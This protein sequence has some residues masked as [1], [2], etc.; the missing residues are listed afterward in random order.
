[1]AGST[2]TQY[3][4]VIVGSGFAGSWAAKEL[5]EAGFHTLILEAGPAL[6]PDEI[7]ARA[8][9][10]G[11]NLGGPEVFAIRSGGGEHEPAGRTAQAPWARQRV[12]RHHPGFTLRGP[13]LFVDDADHP[14]QTPPDMPYYWI[15]GMQLGGRS[16]IWG[17]T[18]L[19][20]SPNEFDAPALDGCELRWPIRYEE[21]ADAY[22]VVEKLTGLQG[23]A[24]G[25]PQLPDS[26]YQA[27]GRP[28]TS[29]EK[30]FQRAYQSPGTRPIPV[31]FIPAAPMQ[32]DWPGFTMQA[33]ALAAAHRTQHLVCRTNSVATEVTVDQ[34]TGLATGIRYVDTRTETRHHATG[35]VVFLCCGSIETTRL[36]LNS[37]GTRHPHG[38]GNS[39]GWLGRGLMDHPVIASLGVLDS[40]P[41]THDDEWS[42]RQCGLVVPPGSVSRE[43]GHGNVRPF[44]IWVNLQRLT[45][46]SPAAAEAGSSSALGIIDAQGEMLPYWHNRVRLSAQR[47]R[48]GVPV[49]VIECA[50]GPHE[51][52]LREVMRQAVARAAA[53]AGLHITALADDLTVPG[54]NA[55]DLGPARMGPTPRASVVNSENRCWDCQN[56]FVTD[57]ACFP[58]AGWQNPTLT[59]MALSARAGRCAAMLLRESVY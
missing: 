37:R 58:S 59:I 18:A 45:G 41:P 51:Q 56:V 2:P 10:H 34:A 19:R 39:S 3:D 24:E 22:A 25:L 28:L 4:A 50:Y 29:A 11:V 9:Y 42:L 31:R 46:Q 40:Y 44:G 55:H 48:W 57:G 13:H 36:M 1:M 6:T 54:L 17:G 26:A 5:T 33:T 7:P 21:L 20:L 38:L 30:D 14:Y 32:G 49:P 53:V 35:R 43:T 23:T 12:Q 15:R 47:D 27:A 16:S 52:R 8:P